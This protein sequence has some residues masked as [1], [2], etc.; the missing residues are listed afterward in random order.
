MRRIIEPKLGCIDWR[1]I[2]RNPYGQN[3]NEL[4]YIQTY[5]V[6]TMTIQS[7]DDHS[8]VLDVVISIVIF[9]QTIITLIRHRVT[10]KT[11]LNEIVILFLI[12]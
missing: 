2:K 11:I 4:Q 12:D 7:P 6:C 10:C 5:G 3:S 9:F 1:Y 8:T